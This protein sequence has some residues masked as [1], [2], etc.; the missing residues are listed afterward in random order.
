MRE[1][2]LEGAPLAGFVGELAEE[3]RETLGRGERLG[4]GGTLEQS[5]EVGRRLGLLPLPLVQ[6]GER[7]ERRSMRGVAIE[8]G[9]EAL[10]GLVERA[11]PRLLYLTEA[12]EVA[13]LG[14]DVSTLASERDLLGEQGGQD[15][16]RAQP[17]R[18]SRE[19]SSAASAWAGSSSST[20]PSSS[21]ASLVPSSS[22]ATLA[23][24]SLRPERFDLSS[25]TSTS[26]VSS[27]SSSFFLPL[28]A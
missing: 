8:H 13:E 18:A 21:I 17:S 4:S 25:F 14:V 6:T 15:R 20:A 24:S 12:H 28:S 26:R 10:D 3:C 22:F 16:R 9:D 1:R 11:E 23:A 5:L 2:S 19:S 27:A 7:L